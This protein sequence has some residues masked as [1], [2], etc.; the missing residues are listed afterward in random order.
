MS[1]R[2][3]RSLVKYIFKM[4]S[5]RIKII[6]Y[7]LQTQRYYFTDKICDW[8]TRYW[9][10]EKLQDARKLENFGSLAPLARNSYNIF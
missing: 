9:Y 3:L 7:V 1:A 4:S 6:L 10:L 2:L 8:P 5:L